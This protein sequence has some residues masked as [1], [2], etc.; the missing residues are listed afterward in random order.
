MLHDV[1]RD[2]QDILSRAASEATQAHAA[3]M[4]VCSLYNNTVESAKFV[5]LETK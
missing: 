5:S 2:Q 3:K 1:N 4:S